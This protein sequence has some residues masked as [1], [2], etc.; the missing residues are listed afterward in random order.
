VNIPVI[1][2]VAIAL[3]KIGDRRAVKPLVRVIEN[4]ET[5][6][7]LARAA[8]A[9]LKRIGDPDG[10]RV[11]EEY[12]NASLRPDRQRGHQEWRAIALAAA[13]LL[14][15]PLLI[16]VLRMSAVV[17]ASAARGLLLAVALY[18][19]LRL[20]VHGWIALASADRVS[21]RT[22]AAF[23]AVL[24][25]VAVGLRLY[26]RRGTVR[27]PGA[28]LAQDFA[29]TASFTVVGAVL[30]CLAMFSGAVPYLWRWVL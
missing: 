20:G 6:P 13:V 25:L 23:A 19:G 2:G 5:D 3:G 21:L 14:F 26:A 18:R 10:V 15:G 1:E 27:S 30:S 16:A 11:A 28:A 8:A 17:V 22:L 9:A 4:E 24:L 12:L 7:I 29:Q